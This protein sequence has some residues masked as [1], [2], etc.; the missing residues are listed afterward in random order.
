MLRLILTY[1]LH[2]L[3][4]IKIRITSSLYNYNP[5]HKFFTTG[6]HTIAGRFG[7]VIE[8]TEHWWVAKSGGVASSDHM[9]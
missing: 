8:P 2:N 1:N 5:K 7:L 3:N 9:M 4:I 6:W